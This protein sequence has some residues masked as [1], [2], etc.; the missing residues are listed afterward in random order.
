VNDLVHW[1]S[2]PSPAE[3]AE[4]DDWL[5]GHDCSQIAVIAIGD[6][7][8]MV[9]SITGWGASELLAQHDTLADALTSATCRLLH[10]S[11]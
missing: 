5:A 9:E 11:S 7:A 1:Y 6:T 3:R 4:V 10:V 2:S 8:V